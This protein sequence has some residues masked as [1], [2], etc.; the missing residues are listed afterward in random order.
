MPEMNEGF[1]KPPINW[2][3]PSKE[4][5][6]DAIKHETLAA[7]E[8]ELEQDEDPITAMGYT[9]GGLDSPEGILPNDPNATE[10]KR[11]TTEEKA[12]RL[13]SQFLVKYNEYK[14]LQ[15]DRSDADMYNALIL[16]L[17]EGENEQTRLYNQILILQEQITSLA[18]HHQKVRA[19]KEYLENSQLFKF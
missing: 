5:I 4:Q 8:S 7:A 18:N 19:S 10:R 6:K 2:E 14:V 15:G 9:Y 13:I 16:A 3:K 17:R 11:E 1:P 12:K